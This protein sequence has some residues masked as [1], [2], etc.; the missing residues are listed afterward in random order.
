[1]L[2]SNAKCIYN[3]VTEAIMPTLTIRDVPEERI[4]A[5]KERAKRNRRSMQAEVL[6]ILDQVL[7]TREE[8]IKA[9][10]DSWCEQERPTTPEEI[11]RW[12]KD[13]RP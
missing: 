12:L 10:E 1:M 6:T 7:A 9:I 5:L 11:G 2:A 8:T 13:S 3:D 4:K